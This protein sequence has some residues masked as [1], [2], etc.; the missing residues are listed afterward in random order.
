MNMNVKNEKKND[1]KIMKKDCANENEK[2]N[3]ANENEKKVH[4]N[5]KINSDNFY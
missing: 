2:K 4:I 5:I 1:V 3:N